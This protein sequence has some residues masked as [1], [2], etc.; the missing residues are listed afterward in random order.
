MYPIIICMY[1]ANVLCSVNVVHA[2][3]YMHNCVLYDQFLFI[4]STSTIVTHP[5]DTSAAAP[6]SGVFSCSVYGY[7]YQH[8]TWHRASG[9]LP[10]KHVIKEESSSNIITSTLIIPNVTEQDAGKYYCQAWTSNLG[11]QSEQANL[12]YSGIK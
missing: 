4:A 1:M 6:F 2:Y 3:V 10:Y 8:I 12:F 5:V 7:G 9:K 11:T